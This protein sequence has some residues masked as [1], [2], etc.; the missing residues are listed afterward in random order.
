MGGNQ[1]EAVNINMQQRVSCLQRTRHK[2]M[3]I[4]QL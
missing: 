3:K 1:E 4:P 2:A